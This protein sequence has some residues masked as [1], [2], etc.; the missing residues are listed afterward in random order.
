MA[1]RDDQL[2]DWAGPIAMGVGTALSIW[3][4]ANQTPKY[5]GSVPTH[6]PALG[7]IT[8]EVGFVVAAVCCT[9][10]LF[11]KLVRPQHRAAA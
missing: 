5:I 4:F 11:P 1:Q 9:L 2:S 7:D 8:F 3:L 6:H 10:A